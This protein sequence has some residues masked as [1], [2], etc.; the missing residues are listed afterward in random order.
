MHGALAIAIAKSLYSP[1][2]EANRNKTELDSPEA[3]HS[4]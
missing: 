1:V 4:E 3:A 2:I